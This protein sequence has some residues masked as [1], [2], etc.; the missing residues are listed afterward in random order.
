MRELIVLSGKGG[1]GKT[2]LTAALAHL[3]EGKAVLADLDVDAAN[4][5]LVLHAH[6]HDQ[7]D[8]VSGHVARVEASQCSGCGL[9]AQ[10][11]RFG[12]VRM[13][14]G[15][16]AIVDPRRCEGCKTCVALCPEGAMRFDP[17]FCGVW[18]RSHT[19]FGPMVHARLEPGG[20][21]SGRLVSV[22]KQQARLWAAQLGR[23]LILAD[24]APG[25]GCPVIAS[26]SQAHWAV[27]VTEPSPS[28]LHDL[29]RV[30]AVCARFRVPVAVVLNKWDLAPDMAA[31]VEA[32]CAEQG[33][34]LLG[35]LPHDTAVPWAMA[36]GMA[37]TETDGPWARA[38]RAMWPVLLQKMDS[39][40]GI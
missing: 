26:L 5:H 2:T 7:E 35:R 4:L 23:E 1:T 9:C 11:C 38:V 19:R 14:E 22:V 24:G 34:M 13:G 28:G 3:A 15:G 6:V 10:V 20:E 33:W 29:R 37:V 36:Q 21:N 40:G 12:A 8:F 16:T 32:L 25:I 30:A 39:Q 18:M 31:A 17:R 27:L